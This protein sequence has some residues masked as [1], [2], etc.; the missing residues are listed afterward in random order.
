M[1]K[2][3]GGQWKNDETLGKGPLQLARAWGPAAPNTI[4]TLVTPISLLSSRQRPPTSLPGCLK[5]LLCLPFSPAVPLSPTLAESGV[6]LP[7]PPPHPLALAFLF[8]AGTP[9]WGLGTAMGLGLFLQNPFRAASRPT[10]PLYFPHSTYPYLTLCCLFVGG[11]G[12]PLSAAGL[13]LF[14]AGPVPWG[15]PCSRMWLGVDPRSPTHSP[16]DPPVWALGWL[17]HH[18]CRGPHTHTQFLTT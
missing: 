4:H 1:A 12:G 3:S 16:C 9:A 6:P 13:A 14:P 11:R 17:C 8:L 7:P 18:P 5:C 2:A 10:A 15:T